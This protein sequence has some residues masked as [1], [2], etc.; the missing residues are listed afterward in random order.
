MVLEME[1]RQ[2]I[3]DVEKNGKVNDWQKGKK[4]GIF[5]IQTLVNLG[6]EKQTE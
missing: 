3:K 6:I 5:N 1:K 4:K 2:S